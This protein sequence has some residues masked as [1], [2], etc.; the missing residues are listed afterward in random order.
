MSSAAVR[1]SEEPLTCTESRD[2]VPASSLK[3]SVELDT[4]IEKLEDD[5]FFANA[6][7][8]APTTKARETPTL[9]I[10]M[11][12]R[13]DIIFHYLSPHGKKVSEFVVS[14]GGLSYPIDPAR[15]N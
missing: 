2:C 6:G 10:F 3:L 5:F 4:E 7:A 8:A 14:T 15:L 12:R 1:S 11:D 13:L 9:N